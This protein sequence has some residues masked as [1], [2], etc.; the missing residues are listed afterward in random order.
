MKK[1]FYSV[2]AAA[3]LL[4]TTACGGNKK[5]TAEEA[6]Y[7]E[8]TSEGLDVDL[9]G[10]GTEEE[11]VMAQPAFDVEEITS[12]EEETD[13][14]P[15]TADSN[16]ATSQ[17]GEVDKAAVKAFVDSYEF[18]QYAENAKSGNIDKMIEALNWLNKTNASL[19]SQVR[20]LD[21]T[22]IAK[23]VELDIIEKA[24]ADKY[25]RMSLD[26]ALYNLTDEMSES[27]LEK[28]NSVSRSSSLFFTM[29]DTKL[30]QEY[31]KIYR[32]IKNKR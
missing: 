9:A 25:D 14:P 5:E 6:Q 30:S 32:E 17:P 1:I 26:G 22:A 2:T 20:A 21:K 3:L 8:I 28:Y 18:E 31:T 11:A 29:N 10:D 13:A 4:G 23:V 7:V 19:K 12:S 15:T 16:E 27:Q 24:A